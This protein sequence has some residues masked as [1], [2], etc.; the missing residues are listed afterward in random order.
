[1]MKLLEKK[2]LFNIVTVV[3][4]IVL[5]TL[6]MLPVLSSFSMWL[7]AITDIVIGAVEVLIVTSALEVLI[8][9]KKYRTW[10]YLIPFVFSILGVAMFVFASRASN[11]FT[12]IIAM[13]ALVIDVVAYIITRRVFYV[14]STWSLEE[15]QQHVWRKLRT[16]AS[17]LGREK[18]LDME[19]NFRCY[20]T[21][22]GTIESDLNVS[23]PWATASDD[24][25]GTYPL[26]FRG[27]MA[28][29]LDD[30]AAKIKTDLIA[31]LDKS[32]LL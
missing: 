20:P 5:G 3:V 13:I 27:A 16:K 9:E 7:N 24:E 11:I 19:L 18:F 14:P 10:Q 2:W 21:V 15:E 12:C 31:E 23:N 30:T 29:G 8:G 17:K 1:M 28:R 4:V 6:T 22:D 25:H 26:T 32:G